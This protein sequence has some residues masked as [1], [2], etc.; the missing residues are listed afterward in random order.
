MT[1]PTRPL[2]TWLVG[3]AVLLV[4]TA[5]LLMVGKN[6]PG[7]VVIPVVIV[8]LAVATTTWTVIRSRRQRL[9]YE[10]RLT[11]WA[12]EQA[13]HHERLR[14]ARE[15]HDI[16]SH[17][18]GVIVVRAT[19]ARRVRG[20][21]REAER[22]QAL[23]DIE[24]TGR[25]AVA[26]LR[27]MLS[28]L[29]DNGERAAPLRP[30]QS[31]ADIPAVVEAARATGLRP[32]LEIADLGDVSPGVQATAC[33]VVR[34]AVTNA[35]RYAGPAEVRIGLVREGDVVVVSIEDGGPPEHWQPLRGAGH[36]LV[37]LRERV[38]A[39][40]GELVVHNGER[41]FHVIARLPD[42]GRR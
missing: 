21:G 32:R 24:R 5:A 18:L 42:G 28:V 20:D 33:A 23:A 31:L 15:L 35:A 10:A 27:R 19:A 17:G 14:I 6:G 38:D 26:E 2:R 7:S 12:A 1:R 9:A 36:G 25:E 34:E 22:D 37:G 39:L 11:S 16:V 41:G 3:G 13:A 29:R 40:G 8:A 30:A 4:L